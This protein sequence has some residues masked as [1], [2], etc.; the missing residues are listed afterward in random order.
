MEFKRDARDGRLKFIEINA[1]H[2]LW[3][4][5]ATAAGVNLSEIAYRD[6]AGEVIDAAAAGGW[7]RVERSAAGGQGLDE[8]VASGAARPG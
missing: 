8:R 2:G 4:G 1:R 6:A 3:A 5:L 7:S